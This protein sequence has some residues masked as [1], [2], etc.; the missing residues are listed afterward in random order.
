MLKKNKKFFCRGFG[1]CNHLL[2]NFSASRATLAQLG[3][4]KSVTAVMDVWGGLIGRGG[5]IKAPDSGCEKAARLE[6][7]V[8]FSRALGLRAR[9]SSEVAPGRQQ[10]P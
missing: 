9:S 3:R 5:E 2:G 8:G 1:F 7:G 10:S 6:P 4:G